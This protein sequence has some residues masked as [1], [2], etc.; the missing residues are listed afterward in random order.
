MPLRLREPFFLKGRTS[1]VQRAV[2]MSVVLGG[3]ASAAAWLHVLPFALGLITEDKF[4]WARF[5]VSAIGACVLCLPLNFW[6]G[7]SWAF[8]MLAILVGAV[9]P[10]LWES[11]YGFGLAK[12]VLWSALSGSVLFRATR[13]HAIAYALSILLSALIPFADR[14]ANSV[15]Y[16]A[17]PSALA[18]PAAWAVMLGSV[19]FTFATVTV[20]W[21]IPFWWPPEKDAGAETSPP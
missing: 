2:I 4:P 7:R 3:L 19:A 12:N 9:S 8:G 15:N 20:P 6:N 14:A 18:V 11:P 5:A 10:V 16:V 17:I 1:V 13:R 21:G